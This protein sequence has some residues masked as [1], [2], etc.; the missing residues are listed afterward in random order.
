MSDYEKSVLIFI[1]ILGFGDI[2]R[3][4]SATEI[5]K[6]LRLANESSSTSEYDT[7]FSGRRSLSFSD[8]I[9][10]SCPLVGPHGFLAH[11]LLFD[12]IMNIV[13]LQTD[14]ID[15]GGTFLRGAL[16][17]GDV[18]HSKDMVFGP[19]VIDA[20]EIESKL[21][22][23]PRVVI[24]PKVLLDYENTQV[25]R[26]GDN[27]AEDDLKFVKSLIRQDSDGLWFVDYLKGMLGNFDDPEYYLTFLKKHK[28]LILNKASENKKLNGIA[29]KYNWLARYHNLVVSELF[30]EKVLSVDHDSVFIIEKEE[31]ET[32]HQFRLPS[33]K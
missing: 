33:Q 27:S 3:K 4:T 30:K 12:E 20:Y 8:T 24:D 9:I 16:T 5:E 11:G 2:V 1:D 7:E 25:L 31:L 14:M 23:Y 6:L 18:H 22:N 17:V 32:M 28:E 13:F 26:Y 29:L 10:T 19:A 21:C 15:R